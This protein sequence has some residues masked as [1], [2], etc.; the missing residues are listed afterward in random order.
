VLVKNISEKLRTGKISEP[1]FLKF[2]HKKNSE[3]EKFQMSVCQTWLIKK[4]FITYLPHRT[5][6]LPFNDCTLDII[7]EAQETCTLSGSFMHCDGGGVR[8][9]ENA[10]FFNPFVPRNTGLPDNPYKKISTDFRTVGIREGKN[11]RSFDHI[12]MFTALERA[13]K[14]K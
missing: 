10:L 2:R 6:F 9:N 7:Q 3:K 14:T 8:K 13:F 5:E 4:Y 1:F 11:K 12:G